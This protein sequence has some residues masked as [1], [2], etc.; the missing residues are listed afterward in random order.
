MVPDSINSKN[1]TIE[2]STKKKSLQPTSLMIKES[3]LPPPRELIL[4]SP[5]LILS[6]ASRLSWDNL[7]TYFECLGPK[8]MLV[9]NKRTR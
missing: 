5:D 9:E 2:R 4:A 3:P 6:S 1:G 7:R 8:Q